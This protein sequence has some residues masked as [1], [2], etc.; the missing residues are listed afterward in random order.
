[1][2]NNERKYYSEKDK[3]AAYQNEDYE[4]LESQTQ[5]EALLNVIVADT[6]TNNNFILLHEVNM[7][8]VKKVGKNGQVEKNYQGHSGSVTKIFVKNQQK[9][10][11]IKKY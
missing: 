8:F 1:M 2:G 11:N 3:V 10:K 9:A 7:K 4:L 6:V 5:Q